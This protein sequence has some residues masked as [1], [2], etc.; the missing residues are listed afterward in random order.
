MSL[1]G[2]RF[3]NIACLTKVILSWLCASEMK[4][5]LIMDYFPMSLILQQ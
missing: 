5:V 2:I 1:P 3:S 4:L